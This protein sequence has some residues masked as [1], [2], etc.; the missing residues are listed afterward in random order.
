[1]RGP[2]GSSGF[3]KGGCVDVTSAEHDASMYPVAA[4][5]EQMLPGE[6]C[7]FRMSHR[8]CWR[9]LRA[10]RCGFGLLAAVVA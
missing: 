7:T 1:V 10:A 9:G 6:R 3:G 5:D 8:G 2:G 4:E